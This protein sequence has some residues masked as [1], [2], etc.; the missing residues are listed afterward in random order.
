MSVSHIHSPYIT[1]YVLLPI[2]PILPILS[3]LPILPMLHILPI[4]LTPVPPVG[5]PFYTISSIV[6][7]NNSLLDQNTHGHGTYQLSAPTQ[8]SFNYHKKEYRGCQNHKKKELQKN[9]IK[10]RQQHPN[11]TRGVAKNLVIAQ[12]HPFHIYSNIV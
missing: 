11:T 7:C 12:T 4:P 3:I 2:L 10:K 9:R 1:Q 5:I 6:K 8:L